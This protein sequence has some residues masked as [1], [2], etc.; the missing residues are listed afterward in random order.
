MRY[1][2]AT[3]FMLID[4]G[5]GRVAEWRNWAGNVVATPRGASGRVRSREVRELVAGAARAGQLSASPAR[6]LLFP[7][8]ATDGV[9]LD[10]GRSRRCDRI[11]SDKQT[12]TI[13][14]GTRIHRDRCTPCSTQ[15]WRSR[16]RATS[17]SRR[18][19]GQ[20]EPA[21][22]GRVGNSARFRRPWLAASWSP[23]SGELLTVD[24]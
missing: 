9:L 13:L 5:T 12:A 8:C 7:I 14:G 4:E 17:M 23:S 11:D 22:T 3:R 18:S 2:A 6:A 16:T 19:R 15:G 10:F 21:P 20:L 24:E 1:A